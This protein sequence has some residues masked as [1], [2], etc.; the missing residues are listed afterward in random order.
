MLC[1]HKG[2]LN[3]SLMRFFN[4]HLEEVLGDVKGTPWGYLSNAMETSAATKEVEDLLLE[5]GLLG[6]KWG[7]VA[8]AYVMTSPIA[9][10]QT[11]RVRE[12]M[13]IPYSIQDILFDSEDEAKTF[14]ENSV[15]SFVD[16]LL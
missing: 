2:T 3:G 13:G 16:K 14:L 12:K 8:A 6:L 10:A 9:I 5:S 11:Q 7:C 1:T 4:T 15:Q